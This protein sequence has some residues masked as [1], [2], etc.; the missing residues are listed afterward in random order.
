[1]LI[2][3][4]IIT[5]TCIVRCVFLMVTALRNS[6]NKNFGGEIVQYIF[7]LLCDAPVILIVCYNHH[8]QF[9]QSVQ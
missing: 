4:L 2:V 3:F 5:L 6:D 1:L 8:K 7:D 9:A